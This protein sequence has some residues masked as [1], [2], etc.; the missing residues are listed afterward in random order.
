MVAQWVRQRMDL[1]LQAD[2]DYVQGRDAEPGYQARNGSRDNDLCAS[3]LRRVGA[4]I[5]GIDILLTSSFNCS[6]RPDMHSVASNKVHA[7]WMWCREW[8]R[9]EGTSLH[10]AEVM[11]ARRDTGQSATPA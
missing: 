4:L 6:T 8:L 5:A 1:E 7:G 2:L 9:L 10:S 3:A 11:R